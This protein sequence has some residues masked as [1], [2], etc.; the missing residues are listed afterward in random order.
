MIDL[1]FVL[2]NCC[3]MKSFDSEREKT[4]NKAYHIYITVIAGDYCRSADTRNVYSY[5][6]K[7]IYIYHKCR[8]TA[9]ARDHYIVISKLEM[10]ERN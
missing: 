6:A 7:K 3:L 4:Q 1:G 9:I 8:L 2:F 10:G 5:S